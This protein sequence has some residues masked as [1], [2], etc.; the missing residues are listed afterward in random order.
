MT[1][2]RLGVLAVQMTKELAEQ[3]GRLADANG[4]TMAQEIRAALRGHVERAGSRDKSGDA[5]A[6]GRYTP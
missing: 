5:A 4:R 2:T 1:V 6:G 3:M